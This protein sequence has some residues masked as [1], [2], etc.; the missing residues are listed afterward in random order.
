MKIEQ[1]ISEKHLIQGRKTYFLFGD[2][3]SPAFAAKEKMPKSNFCFL[4][5]W[6]KLSA[7]LENRFPCENSNKSPVKN[8]KTG[9]ECSCP[10]KEL[11]CCRSMDLNQCL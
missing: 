5:L 9:N 8:V 2:K 7:H 4:F 3:I 1:L 10:L 6:G 11:K